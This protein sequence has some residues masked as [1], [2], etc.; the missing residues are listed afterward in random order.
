MCANYA[1]RFLLYRKQSWQYINAFYSLILFAQDSCFH[2][3]KYT[4]V[5][6]YLWRPTLYNLYPKLNYHN[7]MPNPH[8]YTNSNPQ[9]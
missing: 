1:V 2:K 7:Y 4:F 5:F 6:V 3:Q 9:T 8:S